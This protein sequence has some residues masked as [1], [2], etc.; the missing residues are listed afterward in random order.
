MDG[1]NLLSRRLIPYSSQRRG[2]KW[3]RKIGEFF[4]D[5]CVYNSFIVW[6]KLNPENEIHHLTYRRNIITEI[7]SFH[8]HGEKPYRIGPKTIAHN[9]LRLGGMH[10]IQLYPQTGKKRY[11]QIKCVACNA[12]G[13]LTDSRYWCTKCGVGLCL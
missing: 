2:V 3:C 12:S 1:V 7:I 8:F 5:I 10:F 11:P 4:L 9:P 13:R 6:L